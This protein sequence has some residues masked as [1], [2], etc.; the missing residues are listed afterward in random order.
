MPIK[1]DTD[2]VRSL[3]SSLQNFSASYEN[4]LRAIKQSAESAN[5]QSQARE[6][7]IQDLNLVAK[8]GN[9]SVEA[10]RL[11]SRATNRKVDQWEAIGNIFNGPFYFLEGIWDSFKNYLGNSWN[12]LIKT[13]GS[14]RWPT[15]TAIT[16]IATG[17]VSGFTGLW[18]KWDFNRPDWWPWPTKTNETGKLSSDSEVN[19]SDNNPIGDYTVP[20]NWSEKFNEQSRIQKEI[21]ITKA[22]ISSDPN[23]L[24]LKLRLKQLESQEFAIQTSINQGITSEPTPKDKSNKLGGC[25]NYVASKRN[26]EGFWQD[27]H[28]NATYWDENARAA[29]FDVGS[30][31]VKGS[32]MVIEADNDNTKKIVNGIMDVHATAGHV[33]YVEGVTNVEGGY[34]VSISHGG[35]KYYDNGNYIPGTYKPLPPK[36]LFIP[37]E[38]DYVSFIY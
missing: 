4:R 14:I 8:G 19:F 27:S 37:Y 35:T 21:E 9:L 25:T 10:L 30:Q 7:F 24:L 22:L 15:A 32:I 38:S 18:P 20:E 16:G 36:T 5:W 13:M 6:E 26:V 29:G 3:A 2:A 31:P 1:M 12:N 23:D 17:I 34:M 28:M 33:A 11:M